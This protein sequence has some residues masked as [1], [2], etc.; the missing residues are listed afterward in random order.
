MLLLGKIIIALIV[1]AIVII[2]LGQIIFFV[3]AIN[4]WKKIRQ[5]YFKIFKHYRRID[6]KCFTYLDAGK[7]LDQNEGKQ[8]NER[9]RLAEEEDD[10]EMYGFVYLERV[11]RITE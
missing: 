10:N 5:V 1:I 8:E 11:E 2:V 6:F 4:P 9:W 7:L 3:I